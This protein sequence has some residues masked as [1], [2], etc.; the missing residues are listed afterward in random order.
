MR[1]SYSLVVRVA[2]DKAL[3][4]THNSVMAHAMVH[5]MV[6]VPLIVHAIVTR[7]FPYRG[8]S[9]SKSAVKRQKPLRE[10]QCFAR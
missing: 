10:A 7:S 5:G 6:S 9:I 2:F 1:F 3:R 4:Y 8:F